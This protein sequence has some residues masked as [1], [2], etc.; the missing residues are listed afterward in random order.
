MGLIFEGAVLISEIIVRY[1]PYPKSCSIQKQNSSIIFTPTSGDGAYKK[2]TIRRRADCI[3]PEAGL[4]GDIR[5]W[6]ETVVPRR[7]ITAK[8]E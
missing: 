4:A 7:G 5:T 3:C 1:D 2:V 6:H 8:S